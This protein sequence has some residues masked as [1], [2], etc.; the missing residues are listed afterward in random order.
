MSSFFGEVWEERKEEAEEEVKSVRGEDEER[1]DE[2]LKAGQAGQ[3]FT[4]FVEGA[5]KTCVFVTDTDMTLEDLEQ[6]IQDAMCLPKGCFF[7]TLSG[8][9]L[10][11]NRM[12]SLARDI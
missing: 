2:F 1:R 11:V 12:S 7:L 3:S 6:L 5:G 10:E 8:K 9:M 4:I